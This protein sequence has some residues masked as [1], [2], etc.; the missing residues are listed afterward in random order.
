MSH[1]RSLNLKKYNII[2]ADPPWQFKNYND[3]KAKN[4]VGEHYG[5]LSTKDICNLPISDIADK[6]CVLFI[7]GT[8]PKLPDCLEVIKAWGFNYKTCGFNWIK[9]NKGNGSL[10]FGMGYWTRS[11]SEFCLLATKGHPKRVDANVFQ[12]LKEP[13]T[14]HSSKPSVTRDYVVQLV[15]NLPRIELFARQ[16]TDG[17]DVW[18]NE[19]ESDIN[20]ETHNQSFQRT[21]R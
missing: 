11:N 1:L 12:V 5:L 7:W 2:Y 19:V 20:L 4:W 8:W 18:G 16:K 9:T 10:F 6:D 14:K 17:W 15:G 13:R 21:S 3:K